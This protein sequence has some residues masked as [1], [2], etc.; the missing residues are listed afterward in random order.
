MV[1]ICFGH[2]KTNR[3]MIDIFHL[4]MEKKLGNYA[5][6]KYLSVKQGNLQQ[7]KKP[8]IMTYIKKYRLIEE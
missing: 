7:T 4:K 3:D 6:I 8:N 1:G 5:Q 2:T